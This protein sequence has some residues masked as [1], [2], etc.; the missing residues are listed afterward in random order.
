MKR[1]N[2]GVSVGG[3][4][5]KDHTFFFASYE[6]LRQHQGILQNAPVFSQAQQNAF[7][8]NKTAEPI[9]A[10]FA[11]AASSVWNRYMASDRAAPGQVNVKN[12]SW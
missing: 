10:A 12:G 5:W 1:N 2:Y 6:A 8:A 3:P 7:A 9:A 4:V 11:L